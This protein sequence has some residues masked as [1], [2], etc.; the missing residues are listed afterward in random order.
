MSLA[1]VIRALKVTA[2]SNEAIERLI[3]GQFADAEG[4]S[5]SGGESTEVASSSVASGEASRAETPDF[6][7]LDTPPVDMDPRDQEMETEIAANLSGDPLAEYDLEVDKE[8]EAIF[9]Y[10]GLVDSLLTV[11]A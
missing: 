8:G 6:G 10:L 11:S 2:N 9:E 4:T 1:A 3:Q 7:G 5:T